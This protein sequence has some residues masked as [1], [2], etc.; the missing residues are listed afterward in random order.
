M[1]PVGAL[2]LWSIALVLL[3]AS[4]CQER[5]PV[6]GTP[7][8]RDEQ[9]V[10]ASE[11]A[12]KKAVAD[13]EA[14]APQVAQA[15]PDPK[16]RR[17]DRVLF[18]RVSAFSHVRIVDQGNQ[19]F[20]SFVRDPGQEVIE[21]A[22]N[23]DAPDLL[24][25][26]YTRAMF[27]SYL[28]KPQQQRCVIVGL[29]GGS[30]VRFLNRFFPEVQVD[31]VEI[32]PVV[33]QVAQDYFGVHAGPKAA[34]FVEDGFAFLA[35]AGPLYDSIYIDAFVKPAADTDLEGMPLRLKTK[36]FLQGTQK[37]LTP[38]GVVVINLND[39][40]NL[41]TD[42]DL[43]RESFPFFYLFPVPGTGNYIAVGSTTAVSV[44][45]MR[46]NGHVVD[47]RGSHGFS[48]EAMSNFLVR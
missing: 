11:S 43:I 26:A 42:I 1:K 18:D 33:V 48:F 32:D 28:L 7:R 8:S 2:K 39:Q 34:L 29:G 44:G 31:M 20:L 16:H 37:R 22:I 38:G 24:A 23:L 14:D 46:A 4:G 30:M 36:Q 25:V 40:P 35:K 9:T 3:G 12:G 13:A 47:L 15:Q 6:P 17:G 10:R 45:E 27:V 21:S 19:R 41:R 5:T